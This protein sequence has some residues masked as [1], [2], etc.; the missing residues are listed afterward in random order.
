MDCISRR[1]G[2]YPVNGKGEKEWR[3][4]VRMQNDGQ[5][6]YGH[7]IE[8]FPL[9]ISCDY[10]WL[11]DAAEAG[12]G[13]RGGGGEEGGE[14]CGCRE[15]GNSVPT[16]NWQI[17]RKLVLNFIQELVSLL[18]L[19]E[20]RM[21]LPQICCSCSCRQTKQ[22]RSPSEH[23]SPGPLYSLSAVAYSAYLD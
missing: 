4:G 23:N 17:P 20:C 18:V 16:Y 15:S 10:G 6:I 3:R 2:K 7:L 8:G 14:K 9:H 22:K 11:C 13:K 21:H 5:I 12:R 1:T 19:T